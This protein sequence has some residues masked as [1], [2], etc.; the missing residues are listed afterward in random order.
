MV[1]ARKWRQTARHADGLQDN[2]R[3]QQ[4]KIAGVV[5]LAD[6]EHRLPFGALTT[7]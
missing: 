1:A 6:H 2:R 5:H 3:A 4:R 7:R